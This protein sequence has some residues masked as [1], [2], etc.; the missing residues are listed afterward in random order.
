M[1]NDELLIMMKKL[2]LLRAARNYYNK[3]Y[4][5]WNIIYN[6]IFIFK[7]ESIYPVIQLI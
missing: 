3:N 1:N 5:C 2:I 7:S 4:F 6:I